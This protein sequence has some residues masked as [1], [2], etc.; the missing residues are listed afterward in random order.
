MV[1]YKK[2]FDAFCA[3]YIGGGGKSQCLY[4]AEREVNKPE[5]VCFKT[6]D[7]RDIEPIVLDPA[8]YGC[9]GIAFNIVAVH[10]IAEE[11]YTVCLLMGGRVIVNRP[12]NGP[13]AEHSSSCINTTLADIRCHPAQF[14]KKD[15]AGHHYKITESTGLMTDKKTADFLASVGNHTADDLD[16]RPDAKDLKYRFITVLDALEENGI[17]V[18]GPLYTSGHV[19]TDKVKIYTNKV[20]SFNYNFPPSGKGVTFEVRLKCDEGNA[21]ELGMAAYAKEGEPEM[22]FMFYNG[23]NAAYMHGSVSYTESEFFD[24]EQAAIAKIKNI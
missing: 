6:P 12:D 5:T 24:S 4:G 16:D 13:W 11:D 15:I 2:L 9:E 19:K 18:E 8:E 3:L 20:V 1:K 14:F 23:R 10:G 7:G 17:S 21:S 22:Q